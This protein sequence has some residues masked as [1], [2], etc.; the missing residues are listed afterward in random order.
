[1]NEQKKMVRMVSMGTSVAR[2]TFNIKMAG[3]VRVL[4]VDDDADT[5]E[6]MKVILDP[7]TFDIIMTSSTLDGIEL[8]RTMSPDVMVVD[9]M[10]PGTNGLKIISEVRKFSNIPI[11]VISALNKPGVVAHALDQGADDYLAKPMK[12]SMLVAYINKLARRARAEQ[13]AVRENGGHC[14]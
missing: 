5:M 13:E 10:L 11:L 3:I 1:M 8:V 2:T 6:L 14:Q 4:V 7:A 12:S 9:L